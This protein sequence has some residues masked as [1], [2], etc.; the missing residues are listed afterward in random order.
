M[1]PGPDLEQ[2]PKTQRHVPRPGGLCLLKTKRGLLQGGAKEL[3][4]AERPPPVTRLGGRKRREDRAC[5]RPPSPGAS[6]E[7]GQDPTLEARAP[8][9]EGAWAQSLHSLTARQYSAGSDRGRGV[10][11]EQDKQDNVVSKTTGWSPLAVYCRFGAPSRSRRDVDH[12]PRPPCT[13]P[14]SRSSSTPS[15]P[16]QGPS[17]R[18]PSRRTPS[19]PPTPSR[20]HP[21]AHP[22]RVTTPVGLV[23]GKWS[24]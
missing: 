5:A 13:W 8:H 17:P 3:G 22:Q 12:G 23:R 14:P 7:G 15:L 1:E 2:V 11:G 4:A 18:S 19:P 20:L 10:R 21:P 6:L 16:S 9:G 24:Q